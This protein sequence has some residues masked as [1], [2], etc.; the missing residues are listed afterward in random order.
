MLD[1]RRI[2]HQLSPQIH[3]QAGTTWTSMVD[4]GCVLQVTSA[5]EVMFPSV[6]TVLLI[7]TRITGRDIVLPVPRARWRVWEW[8]LLLRTAKVY[9]LVLMLCLII[10]DY[11]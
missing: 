1:T 2:S 10:S 6:L 3:V 5:Q 7:V 11:S 9:C 8:E 4:V